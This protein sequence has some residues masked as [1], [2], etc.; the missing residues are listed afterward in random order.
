MGTP[1]DDER[2]ALLER[3]DALFAAHPFEGDVSNLIREQRDER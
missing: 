1:E 2:R 3:L